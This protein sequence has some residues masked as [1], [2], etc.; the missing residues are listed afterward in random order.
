MPVRGRESFA[1]GTGGVDYLRGKGEGDRGYASAMETAARPVGELIRQWRRHRG[2]AQMTLALDA[3][4]SPRHLS[5]LESG[6]SRPSREM[7]L[8]LTAQLEVPLRER[9]R[10]LV[11]A[12][13]APAFRDRQLP[14]SPEDP[15]RRAIELILKGQEPYPALAIDRHWTLLAANRAVAPLLSGVDPE[16]LRPPVNV[17]RLSLHPGGLAPRIVNLPE[18]R[19]HLIA[20]LRRD[21]EASADPTLASLL[22]ELRAYPGAPATEATAPAEVV[23]PLTLR[24]EAGV[25]AFIS[26]TTVFGTATDVLLSEVALES[27]YP[28]DEATAAALRAI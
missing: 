18:W 21:L 5:F 16:L 2:L 6:R 24:T 28:V 23:V 4:I 22:E 20:R 14:D 9:N 1:P 15:A 3:E 26:T 8:R 12:G 19:A 25:L 17:L 7:L 13:F 27:F 10:M 11:A